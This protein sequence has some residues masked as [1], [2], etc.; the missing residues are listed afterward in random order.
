M[1]RIV[2]DVKGQ[3]VPNLNLPA[4]DVGDSDLLQLGDQM[5]IFGYPGIGGETVTFTSGNV[6]GFSRDPKVNSARAWIKTD[7]TIAGGNSG[8]TAVNPGRAAGRYSHTG[9]SRVRE[10]PPWMLARCSTPIET[11]ASTSAIPHMAVGGFIKRA[12]SG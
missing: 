5:A 11:V 12:A 9:R 8:G 2:A 7:A 3:R 10:L 6:S 1:L 4:V